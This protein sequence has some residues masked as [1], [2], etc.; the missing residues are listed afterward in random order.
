[1]YARRVLHLLCAT[2]QFYKAQAECWRDTPCDG[3]AVA[4]FPGSWDANI[5]APDSRAISPVRVLTANQ[6]QTQEWPTRNPV[7]AEGNGSMVVFDWGYEVGGVVTIEYLSRGAGTLGIAF[8]ESSDFI[9]YVSDESNGGTGTD[10]ALYNAIEAS[11]DGLPKQ[12]TY[13]VPDDR[14]RGGFRYLSLY[15]LT[16]ATL[17]LSVQN[18]SVELSFHPNWENMQAYGGYFH[19]SD[20]NLNKIWY[21]SAY[22]IQTNIMPTNTARV[23]PCLDYGWENN[24]SLYTNGPGLAAGNKRDRAVWAGDFG[25]AI[26]SGRS[27]PQ[28]LLQI[29]NR[30]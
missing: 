27:Q 11:D 25:M 14:A 9:G 29:R 3:P 17:E 16:N 1:M 26:R 20:E 4:S 22:T 2:I 5:L 18:V 12:N 7:A 8:T 15:V 13:T 6:S 21:A 28:N 23:Y 24:A 30:S 19:S 10:G